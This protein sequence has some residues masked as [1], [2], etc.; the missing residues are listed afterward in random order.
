MKPLSHDYPMVNCGQMVTW[1]L[2]AIPRRQGWCPP[3]SCYATSM[4]WKLAKAMYATSS[5]WRCRCRY[6]CMQIY[7]YKHIYICMY[8]YN[9]RERDVCVCICIHTWYVCG[10]KDAPSY[11]RPNPSRNML[12]RPRA[13]GGMII[14]G[15]QVGKGPGRRGPVVTWQLATCLDNHQLLKL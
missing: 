5:I 10:H 2:K 4:T 15:H 13:T 7:I 14:P 12:H 9:Y 6:T 8:I 3:V 11:K 1:W